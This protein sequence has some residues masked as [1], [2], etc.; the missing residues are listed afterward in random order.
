MGSVG[1]VQ[2][3][4]VCFSGLYL[5]SRSMVPHQMQGFSIN[6]RVL[7]GCTCDFQGVSPSHL[8]ILASLFARLFSVLFPPYK[9]GMK[10]ATYVG[11]L[12]QLCC[13][14]GGTLQTNSTGMC[15]GCLQWMDHTGFDTAQGATTS[16]V[17]TAQAPRWSERVLSQVGPVFMQFPGLSHSGFQTLH[18]GTDPDG[19]CVLCP[20]QVQAIQPT[21]CLLSTLSQV[22]H[23]FYAPICSWLLGIP[24]AS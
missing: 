14:K 17:H 11:S 3:Q 23:A 22:T 8:F 9:E 18:K 21:G 24:G 16:W 4:V 7:I 13:G 5:F 10:V 20:F 15:G 2:C 1:S 12:V 19:L 6:F